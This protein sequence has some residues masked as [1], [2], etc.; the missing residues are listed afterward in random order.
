MQKNTRNSLDA[1]ANCYIYKNR[2]IKESKTKKNIIFSF[3]I[4]P[5][6]ELSDIR[7]EQIPL[8]TKK[9]ITENRFIYIY[10]YILPPSVI[11][12]IWMSINH[13]TVFRR[14]E[15]RKRK[16]IQWNKNVCEHMYF[17]NW[18][19]QEDDYKKRKG[20]S[21]EP[22]N[23][24]ILFQSIFVFFLFCLVNCVKNTLL[25]WYRHCLLYMY[26]YVICLF[27]SQNPFDEYLYNNSVDTRLFL[28]WYFNI[29]L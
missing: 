23:E 17:E 13:K 20:L 21:T 27:Q 14:N 10:F 5:H 16:T 15:T 1:K 22:S 24:I 2:T 3:Y 19:K 7:H 11:Y 8:S 26:I 6:S 28:N 25:C 18:Q 4:T 29:W 12:S 9:K